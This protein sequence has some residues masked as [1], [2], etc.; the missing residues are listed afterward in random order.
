MLAVASVFLAGTL[1]RAW[2]ISDGAI[3]H[4]YDI[5]LFLRWTR[6]LA[7][8]DLSSFYANAGFCDYPPLAM[9]VFWCVAQLGS[10]LDVLT[11]DHAMRVLLK[12]PAS[13]ADIG[14]SIVLLVEG[15][16]LLGRAAGL[17][18]AAIYLLNPVAWYNSAFFGQVDSVHT[19]LMLTAIVF[20]N[21]GRWSWCG[22]MAAAA[23]LAKF[24]AIV[25]VP[26]VVFE[27]WRYARIRGLGRVCIGAIVA[28]F[29]ILLPFA[30]SG[31]LHEIITRSYI[32]VV[33][34]FDHLS[35]SAFNL[36]RLLGNEHFPDTSIP[37][38]VALAAANGQASIALS[39]SWLL[40]FSY[41]KISLTVFSIVVAILLSL[42]A[43]RTDSMKRFQ[44]GGLLVLAFFLFPTEMHERYAHPAVA[45]LAIWAVSDR[46][47]ER[48]FFVLSMLLVLNIAEIEPAGAIGSY[49]G[50]AII[51]LFVLGACLPRIVDAADVPN[52]PEAPHGDAAHKTEHARP[53][54]ANNAPPAS[55]IVSAFQIATVLSV[56]AFAA[57]AGMIVKRADATSTMLRNDAAI[58]LSRLT[59]E[60]SVQAW[61]RLQENTSVMGGTIVLN[62]VAYPTGIGTHAPSHTTYLVPK[63]AKRFRA[64]VGIDKSA[65]GNGSAHALVITD[66]RVVF[67]ST[68]LRA[69]A[70][71][72]EVNIPVENV[73]TLT[74]DTDPAG[75][76]NNSD[77]ISWALA[78][79]ER[80]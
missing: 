46:W 32:N 1:F 68:L 17:G 73:Q 30:L 54:D 56:L 71:P 38:I 40:W 42:H 19:L 47:R 10:L 31:I 14:I 16:R 24:Q 64:V 72:V 67:E 13:L 39:D 45:L 25:I 15:K 2:M 34:Q 50:A 8:H 49:I 43:R 7:S 74:L 79:F 78:R 4:K 6:A 75:D 51:V 70:P 33:G 66:N 18:A 9:L 36:W 69:N 29:W 62:N 57:C 28:S 58:Y 11:N 22:A 59:P 12:V 23:V 60:S 48:V 37:R 20:A 61:G 26:L 63:G 53:N 76:G 52:A 27:A 80:D 35:W 3:G 65:G 41:R 5:S 44:T 21:R 77:H 55:R